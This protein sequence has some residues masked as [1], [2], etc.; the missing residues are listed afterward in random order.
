MAVVV[1][2]GIDAPTLKD[3]RLAAGLHRETFPL[4]IA[5]RQ[6]MAVGL[7]IFRIGEIPEVIHAAHR[8]DVAVLPAVHADADIGCTEVVIV[9]EIPYEGVCGVLAALA[10]CVLVSDFRWH[11]H[12]PLPPRI[13]LLMQ[14]HSGH[15]A[16]RDRSRGAWQSRSRVM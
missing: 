3:E 5:L 11:A 13:H 14:S 15:P 2:P 8:H 7:M 6:E 10:E 4:D 12:P 1:L 16:L 9:L